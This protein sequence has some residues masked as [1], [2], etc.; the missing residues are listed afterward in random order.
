MQRF[1]QAQARA[2]YSWRQPSSRYLARGLYLPALRSESMGRLAVAVDVSGSVDAVLLAQ[3]S[4]ELQA[5]LDS[6]QPEALDVIYCDARVQK[7]E[8][9]LPGDTVELSACGGG[10]TDFRPVFVALQEE[11]PVALVYLTDLDGS[12]PAAAPDY[13]VLWAATSGAAAPFGE[14]VRVAE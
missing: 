12:F 8:E 6:M 9:Y 1:A 10:G 14:I 3:F 5:I 7:R 4:A 2:D 13:P 11:P